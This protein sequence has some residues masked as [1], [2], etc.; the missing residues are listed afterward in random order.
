MDLTDKEDVMDLFKKKRPDFVVNLAAQAGVRHS[1]DNPD[2]YIQS[3]IVGFFSRITSLPFIFVSFRHPAGILSVR[4]RQT[5]R[6][7]TTFP[8]LSIST[9]PFHN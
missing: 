9:Q 6:T 5:P 7:Y 2:V 3:N 1:I 8:F 4:A